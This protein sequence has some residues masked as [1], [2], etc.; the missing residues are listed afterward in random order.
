MAALEVMAC[1][2]DDEILGAK[3]IRPLLPEVITLCHTGLK[4]SGA[5]DVVHRLHSVRCALSAMMAWR[6]APSP[7]VMRNNTSPQ[8]IFISESNRVEDKVLAECA[9]LLKKASDD[10]YPEVRHAAAEF[11]SVLSSM[12]IVEEPYGRSSKREYNDLLYLDEV[13]AICLRNLDDESVG[14]SVAWSEALARCICAGVE[15]HSVGEKTQAESNADSSG[16]GNKN[17]FTA[18]IKAFQEARRAVGTIGSQSC[19]TLKTAMMFLVQQFTKVGGEGAY[20]LG[21][22]HSMGGRHA[23][24]GISLS[25]IELCKLQLETGGIGSSVERECLDPSAALKTIME[26]VGSSIEEKE[27]IGDLMMIQPSLSELDDSIFTDATSSPKRKK[28]IAKP[29]GVGGFLRNMSGGITESSQKLPTDASLARLATARVLRRGLSEMMSET[30]QQTILRELAALSKPKS[31]SG[32]PE[33]NRHQLQV[34]MVEISHLVTAL[35]EASASCLE[36][37]LPA[38]QYCLS[39]SDHGVRHEAAVAFQAVAIAFPSAG[40]KYIMTMVGEIQVNQDE[41]LALGA[42]SGTPPAQATISPRPQNRRNRRRQAQEKGDSRVS[43]NSTIGVSLHHQYSIHGNA[44]VLSMILHVMPQ[45]PGGLPAELLDIIIAVADNLISCQGNANLMKT[46]PGALVTC[47]RAGYHIISGA[48]TMGPKA[49]VPHLQK[50]F[51]IWSR[52]ATLIEEETNKL[53]QSQSVSCLEP[54]IAS[55]LVFLQ[56]SPEMLLSVPNA[57]KRTTQ[58]LEKLFPIILG[59]S[60][61]EG[62]DT[63]TFTSTRLD[64]AKASIIEAFAWLPPGSYPTISSSV[65]SFAS[66]QIQVETKK[67]SSC[68]I[69]SELLSF[70]DNILTSR[71]STRANQLGQSGNASVEEKIIMLNSTC[72]RLSEREAVLHLAAGVKRNDRRNATGKIS[73]PTPLHEV[74]SWSFPPSPSRSSKER[75]TNSAIHIFAATFGSLDGHQQTGAVQML[76]ELVE[77][78]LGSNGAKVCARNVAATLLSCL[79]ALPPPEIS[80]SAPNDDVPG[81]MSLAAKVFAAIL[82]IPENHARRAAAEGLGLLSSL[83]SANGTNKLQSSI[84][85]ALERLMVIEV[86]EINA[87]QKPRMPTPTSSSAGCLLTF[88]CIQRSFPSQAK[89]EDAASAES[90]LKSID[91]TKVG[92]TIPTMIMMTR[93]LP[94]I[95][96]QEAED[97]SHISRTYALHSFCLLLSYSKIIECESV[98]VEERKQILAKAV[99]VVESNFYAAWTTNDTEGDIRSLEVNTSDQFLEYQIRQCISYI[100]TLYC[101]MK[102]LP[103]NQLYWLS[104]S[105]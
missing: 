78:K 38:M 15:Y 37:L 40:R 102:G 61:M 7:I 27:D 73:L 69:L 54:F 58:I 79:K 67:D 87:Q 101:R 16:A 31:K 55:I 8:K 39:D 46:N 63:K 51:G 70:E 88:A 43:V 12:L 66:R 2:F 48:L 57:L 65:F 85:I 10:K 45:L 20:K 71:A 34:A 72:I 75:L 84:L 23:Q 62:G 32:V 5:T 82:P 26:M 29:S 103:L 89:K 90:T 13:M 22:S 24:V 6:D 104:S 68:T 59:Y 52:S 97:D 21:G 94:Y 92:G 44:L 30:M 11:A 36:E 50:V 4:S 100:S 83:N 60:Q 19:F 81:W 77:S 76:N 25:I 56:N 14:V 33:F 47:V 95:A 96:A 9:R 98:S 99:E 80:K 93:L 91:G 64:S 41:V 53:D 74:G 17:D 1:I 3:Y 42:T 49:T 86:S 18:K 105:N 35:G 28:P